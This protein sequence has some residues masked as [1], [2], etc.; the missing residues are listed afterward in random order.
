ME[1]D[2]RILENWRLLKIGEVCVILEESGGFVEYQLN[3]ILFIDLFL[4]LDFIVKNMFC[5][6][7]SKIFYIIMKNIV[8]LYRRLV[9]F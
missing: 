8:K 6:N 7:E 3:V 5:Y 9:D 1:V 4:K 2:E